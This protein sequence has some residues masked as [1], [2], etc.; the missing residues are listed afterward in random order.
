MS[1]ARSA[2]VSV[3]GAQ[4]KAPYK[5]GGAD[6]YGFDASGLVYFSYKQ[7]NFEIPRDAEGQLRAAQAIPFYEVKPADLLFYRLTE[8]QSGTADGLHVGIYVGSG[9]MVHA[10]LG[11]DKVVLE[12]IDT[13]YWLQRLVVAAKILP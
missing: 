12:S 9:Q 10:P 6:H 2:V 1:D 7:S 11:R 3:A 5:Y 8:K 4:V 13:P